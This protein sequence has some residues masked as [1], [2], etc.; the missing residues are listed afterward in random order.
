M[1]TLPPLVESSS[2]DRARLLLR[3]ARADGPRPGAASRTLTALGVAGTTAKV[4]LAAGSSAGS[5]TGIAT[6]GAASL[7]MIAA[8]WLVV[9]ML[10]GGVLASGAR[11]AFSERAPDAVHAQAAA[12]PSVNT[13]TPLAP[14]RAPGPLEPV[15]DAAAP[16]ASAPAKITTIA[17]PS[18][19]SQ[20]A[21][22]PFAAPSQAAFESPEQSKLLHDVALL[23]DVRRALK[24]GNTAE[25]RAL[26]A[27]YENERQTHVLDREAELL[28]VRALPDNK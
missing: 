1:S 9:G 21:P 26:L 3:A 11:W 25:G 10:G 14:A 17:A 8:K 7:P 4:A 5:A 23:D 2:S 6:S 13:T 19:S 28:R 22:T 12:V 20:S 27:R 15:T 24:S 16:V 18:A